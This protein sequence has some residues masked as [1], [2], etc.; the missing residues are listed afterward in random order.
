MIIL[1]SST[2]RGVGLNSS[3]AELLGIIRAAGVERVGVPW[4]VS[5]ELAAQ[6]AVKYQNE[7]PPSCGSR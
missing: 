4:V 3:S 6:Q 2:L 1:D 7:V 5:E